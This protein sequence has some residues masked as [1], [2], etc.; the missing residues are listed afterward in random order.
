MGLGGWGLGVEGEGVGVM[1]GRI[2]VVNEV[3]PVDIV[4]LD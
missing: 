2:E 3:R 1:L 4:R